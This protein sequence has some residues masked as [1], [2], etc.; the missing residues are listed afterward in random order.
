MKLILTKAICLIFAFNATHALADLATNDKKAKDVKQFLI[1]KHNIQPGINNLKKSILKREV[2]SEV[3]HA[4]MSEY[5]YI[6]SGDT[7]YFGNPIMI[8]PGDTDFDG[9]PIRAIINKDLSEK[10]SKY[11]IAQEN[12]DKEE[13]EERVDEVSTEEISDILNDIDN[14]RSEKKEENKNE[15]FLF[16]RID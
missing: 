10:K 1:N 7:D 11:E 5:E 2:Q 12:K 4:G 9:N 8:Y 6:D 14:I 13:E 15:K 3:R 16:F